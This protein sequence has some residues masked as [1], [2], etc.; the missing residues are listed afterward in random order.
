MKSRTAQ[1]GRP[2]QRPMRRAPGATGPGKRHQ[3]GQFNGR[4]D[5]N[6]TP[7]DIFTVRRTPRWV[8][9]PPRRAPHRAEMIGSPGRAEDSS[10]TPSGWP[11]G[12]AG[13]PPRRWPPTS[14]RLSVACAALAFLAFR[15]AGDAETTDVALP[16]PRVWRDSR[17]GRGTNVRALPPCRPLRADRPLVAPG[18][19]GP[20]LAR[21]RSGAAA[22]QLRGGRDRRDRHRPGLG[23]GAAGVA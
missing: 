7:A 12:S 15:S 6:D 14:A 3:E 20:H 23:S 8:G 16:S 19:I 17:W 1:T 21:H 5:P 22:R 13:R 10:P 9:G 18:R 11:N 2:C 4:S